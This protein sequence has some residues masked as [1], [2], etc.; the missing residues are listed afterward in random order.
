MHGTSTRENRQTLPAPDTKL[1]KYPIYSLFVDNTSGMC[2][3]WLTLLT[4]PVVLRG[5]TII[6]VGCAAKGI[7]QA[8]KAAWQESLADASRTGSRVN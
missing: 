3:K 5:F 8:K 1:W 4:A 7:V 6:I 2:G